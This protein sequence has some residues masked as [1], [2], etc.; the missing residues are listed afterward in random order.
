MGAATG[1]AL[2]SLCV[3]TRSNNP[4]VP[5]DRAPLDTQLMTLHCQPHGIATGFTALF[6]LPVLLVA[7]AMKLTVL[8]AAPATVTV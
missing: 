8:P 5:H 1:W 7:T 2:N 3:V 6:V 4:R